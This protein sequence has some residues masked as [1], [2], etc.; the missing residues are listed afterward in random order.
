MVV[1]GIYFW[2]WREVEMLKLWLVC[3]VAHY[4]ENFWGSEM[5][6]LLL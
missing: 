2:D 6:V 1:I 4:V 3:L 5:G